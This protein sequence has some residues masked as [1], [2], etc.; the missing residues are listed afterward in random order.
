MILNVTRTKLPF[1]DVIRG[2]WS[3][4]FIFYLTSIF[5]FFSLFC[6]P[7]RAPAGLHHFFVEGNGSKKKIV[8]E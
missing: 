5:F 4:P 7:C 6:L 3:T 2:A 1:Q 8:I